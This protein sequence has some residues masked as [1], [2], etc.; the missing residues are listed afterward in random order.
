MNTMQEK[1]RELHE[2]HMKKIAHLIAA[3]GRIEEADAVCEALNVYLPNSYAALKPSVAIKPGAT[4]AIQI[5]AYECDHSITRIRNAI[6]EGEIDAESNVH[7]LYI[8][9]SDKPV[10]FYNLDVITSVGYRVKSQ[11]GVEFRRWATGVLRDYLLK[12]KAKAKM[13]NKDD[14][15]DVV[16]SG[17]S[18]LPIDRTGCKLA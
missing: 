17:K 5:T 8:P 6:N 1:L 3:A 2:E 10:A 15:V 7:F 18:F 4:A 14:Y 12:G 13:K 9:L 16:S 11:R